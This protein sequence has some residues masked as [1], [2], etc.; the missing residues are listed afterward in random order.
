M[1]DGLIQSTLDVMQ[2]FGL[3][4]PLMIVKGDGTLL[5]A[6]QARER[7]V[8]TILS[9]PAASIIGGRHLSG[10]KDALVVDMGGTTTDMAILSGGRVEVDPDGAMVGSWKT[11]VKA[12]R[13]RTVGLGGDSIFSTADGRLEGLTVGPG[14]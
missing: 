10:C 5:A 3:F 9:G 4:V 7:P 6:E 1:I 14:G 2:A 11:H 13:V 8:E 12:A